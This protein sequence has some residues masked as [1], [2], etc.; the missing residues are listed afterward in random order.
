[1]DSLKKSHGPELEEELKK[2]WV[3]KMRDTDGASGPSISSG[4]DGHDAGLRSSV[5]DL[6][7]WKAEEQT[8]ELFEVM[9]RV[10]HPALTSQTPSVYQ[11]RPSKVSLVHRYSTE[12]DAWAQFL[13]EDDVAW[14][15]HNVVE[16]LK[17][18][19]ETSGQDIDTIVAQLEPS[20]E[21]GSGL[22]A[23]GWLDSKLAIKQQKRLRSWPQELAPD[24]PGL[25]KSL[26]N[27]KKTKPLVT[28]LD[29][30]AVT[31][32]GRDLEDADLYFERAIWLACWE[33]IRRGKSWDSIREWCQQRAE[34]WRAT[35][36]RGDPRDSVIQS[37]SPG[38][39]LHSD[40]GWQSRVLWRIMCFVAARKGGINEYEKAV[41]GVLSG[42][43]ASMEKVCRGWDDYLFAH[44]NSYLLR[45]FDHYLQLKFS[46]RPPSTPLPS[47]VVSKPAMDGGRSFAS[48]SEIIEMMKRLGTTSERQ[49]KQPLKALQ[50][51]LIAKTFSDFVFKQGLALSKSANS[52]KM[53]KTIPKMDT[54]PIDRSSTALIS[55]QDH[56]LLRMITHMLFIYQ[57]L[58]LDVGMRIHPWAVENIVVAYMEY[59][60][61][62]GKQQ[63]LP[64]Y[65]SRLSTQR[66]IMCLARLLP[67]VTDDKERKTVMQL[68]GNYKI[69]IPGVLNM[70]LRLIISDT[71]IDG[72]NSTRYPSLK[73]IDRTG[74]DHVGGAHLVRS[75]FI[76]TDIMDDERDLINGFCWYMLLDGYWKQ[77][78]AVGAT[79][80]KHLLRKPYQM[81]FDWT[82]MLINYDKT[83]LGRLAA[84]RQLYKEVPFP[85]L[86]LRKTR[87]ILGRSVDISVE[88]ENSDEEADGQ[89]S[90][91]RSTRSRRIQSR[92]SS[93]RRAR[94]DRELLVK[95]SCVFRDF[96]ALIKTLDVME[97]WRRLV[98]QQP[99]YV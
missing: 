30:D 69:D 91:G 61:E 76:G 10:R 98:D 52:S 2:S 75:D 43:L 88:L 11:D 90:M 7:R 99:E 42:D 3:R 41:Y 9:L 96:E 67:F 17:R 63:L 59:L 4:H 70:Q 68:M 21:R 13:A 23:D 39:Q 5:D 78:M 85:Q 38:E 31:R 82:L 24:S 50:E 89:T 15:R 32:Q 65:A 93:A 77:T 54:T 79:L 29:P 51:S 86:S 36:V 33:M 45:Q 47:Q 71:P 72:K 57:D 1:M 18:S 20:A 44:Y 97:N 40:A 12:Q 94:H 95:E 60:S 46:E 87:S 49:V 56:D 55:M 8:W 34:D 27:S 81:R 53:S 6:Q 14:E 64:L 74:V 66:S 37:R 62:A 83:G 25:D 80:Y 16:W 58:G 92:S 19:A 22:R 84:A 73:I 26:V 35:I 28:Q 48:G